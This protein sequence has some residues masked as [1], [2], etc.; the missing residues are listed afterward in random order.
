MNRVIYLH[1][2]A[3]SPSSSKARYFRQRLEDT[4]FSVTVPDLAEGDFEHLTLSGQLR[5]IDQA[6]AG[7]P[8]ALIGSSMGGYL[9]AL[10]AARHTAIERIILLAPAFGFFRLW[11]ERMGPAAVEDWR[12]RGSIDVFHYG[13]GANRALGYQLLEDAAQFEDYPDVRQPCLIFHGTRD[14]SVPVRYSQQFAATRPNVE[15]HALDSGHELLDVLDFMGVRTLQFLEEISA[16]NTPSSP[17][18]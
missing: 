3:S 18:P 2:F 9:A 14:D 16:R 10:Y 11:V 15:L 1:G 4:G 5:V 12:A 17:A 8:A 7:Q 6:A 13:E